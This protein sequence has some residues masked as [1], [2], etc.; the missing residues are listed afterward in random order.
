MKRNN[1]VLAVLLV[2]VSLAG[3]AARV[4]NVTNLPPGV[5]QKQAQDWDTAVQKLSQVSSLNSAARS[6]IIALHNA[7][8]LKDGPPY[9]TALTV[10]GKVDELQLSASAVLKQSP[11]NFSDSTKAQVQDY[12][13]QIAAQLQ[14]LNQTGVTGIK[15][16]NSQQQ[17]GDLIT[18]L[19]DLTGL[20]LAL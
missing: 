18:Q 15:N 16:P 7:G 11:N 9:V 12:V 5:T 1:A 3:C 2:V 6:S 13:K 10:V 14:T 20:I 8:L 17:I 19:V 4:K